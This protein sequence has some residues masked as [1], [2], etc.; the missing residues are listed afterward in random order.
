MI[1]REINK[2]KKNRQEN[3]L[4]SIM[5]GFREVAGQRAALVANDTNSAMQ[6]S[7]A[8]YST[9]NNQEMWNKEKG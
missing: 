9:E 4:L 8:N 6:L 7:R 3:E 2:E 1:I 5:T